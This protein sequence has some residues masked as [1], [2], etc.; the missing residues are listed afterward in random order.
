MG[1][2]CVFL[3]VGKACVFL[4]G[5]GQAA[6]TR[7]HFSPQH[8]MLLPT[9]WCGWWGDGVADGFV[10]VRR[11]DDDASFGEPPKPPFLFGT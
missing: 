3:D 4:D 6:Y 7:P 11:E 1:K 9:V 10:N 5:S 2:A 8:S